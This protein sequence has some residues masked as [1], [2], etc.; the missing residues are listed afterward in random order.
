[1]KVQIFEDED[2]YFP[3]PGA[4][5]RVGL[6]IRIMPPMPRT[7]AVRR[8]VSGRAYIMLSAMP[9]FGRAEGKWHGRVGE[10]L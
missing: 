8:S 10:Y 5:V 4:L 2:G 3:Y 1:M 6:D 7:S 9:F